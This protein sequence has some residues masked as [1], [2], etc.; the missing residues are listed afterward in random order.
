MTKLRLGGFMI[1][2][3]GGSIENVEKGLAGTHPAYYQNSLRDIAKLS[4]QMDELGFDFVGFTEHHFH[5]EG[6]ETSNTPET[7]LE[8]GISLCG[9]VDT[10]A[11][12]IEDLIEQ[13]NA[14]M[15]VSWIFQG[16]VPVDSLL[17]SNDLLV[18]KVLPKVGVELER[19]QPVLRPE[20][21]GGTWKQDS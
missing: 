14:P 15:V 5:I 3:T 4:R 20:F 16:L 8:R 9:T 19:F 10:M 7:L 13:Y 6:M 12:G 1:P 18:E 2:S 11:R 17:K 21:Q